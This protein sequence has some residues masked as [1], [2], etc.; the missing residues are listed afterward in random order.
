MESPGSATIKKRSLSEAPKGR[1]NPPSRN[2]RIIELHI[3]NKKKRNS[4]IF[5]IFSR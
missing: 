4:K 2:H 5:P 1:G 3:P